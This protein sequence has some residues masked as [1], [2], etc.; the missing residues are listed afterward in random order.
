MFQCPE[1]GSKEVRVEASVL[2]MFHPDGSWDTEDFYY[3]DDAY[4]VCAD[5]DHDSIVERFTKGA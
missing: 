5:C 2:V 4:A 3:N 1:C